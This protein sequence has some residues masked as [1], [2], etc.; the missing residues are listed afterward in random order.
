M[1]KYIQ[2]FLKNLQNPAISK[3]SL[4]DKTSIV[5][6]KARVYE[7]CKIF[8]SKIGKY[9]YVGR[10]TSIVCAEI[11][12]F[13]SISDYN[14]IG[15]GVH[16]LTRISTS[17]IFFSKRNGTKSQWSEDVDTMEYKPLVIGNDVWIGTRTII[18][19]GIRIG[20]G[21]VIAAGAVVT[22]DVPDYAIVAGIPAKI[23]KFRF[24]KDIVD[25]LLLSQWWNYPD[26]YLKKNIELFQT[27][28]VQKSMI[29]NYFRK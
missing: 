25:S 28:N 18:M 2:G 24:D 26:D 15:L 3:F 9:S 6:T 8:D 29:D 21:A 7:F 20:N 12:N 1:N 11:G 4:I 27:S 23:I 16:P 22:K 13:C 19:G 5:N 17:S 14:I 10:N